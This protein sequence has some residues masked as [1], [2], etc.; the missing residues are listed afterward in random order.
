[1][2][3]LAL[4]AA[5]LGSGCSFI[6]SEG[7]P[8]DHRTRESFQCG[9]SAAPPVADTI[10][11]G[12]FALLAFATAQN[13]DKTVAKAAP[14]DQPQV[15]HDTNVAIGALLAFAVIDGASAVYGYH[16]VGSCRAAEQTHLAAVSRVR[17]LPA[18]Y[19]L[20][21]YGEPPRFWPPPL[22]ALPPPAP[23]APTPSPPAF[24]APAPAP[25][26]PTPSP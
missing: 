17:L 7:A 1:M 10:A 16:A 23:V 4:A 20:P 12:A 22:A 5:S 13:E 19:G 6:F 9:D 2:T 21:P 8:D 11:G 14:I 24:D 26:T 25:A 3:A 15:R 18:P